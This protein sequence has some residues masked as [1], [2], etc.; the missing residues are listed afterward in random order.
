MKDPEGLDSEEDKCRARCL[1]L[2]MKEGKVSGDQK[3]LG[4]PLQKTGKQSG[5]RQLLNE[6]S[7]SSVG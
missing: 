3:K 4:P 1:S 2:L 5:F 6:Q 7:Y